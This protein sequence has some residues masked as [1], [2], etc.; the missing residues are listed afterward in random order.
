MMLGIL[1]L[2]LGR[3]G[4]AARVVSLI[5]SAIKAGVIMG[6]GLAAIVVVFDEG[7]RFSQYPFTISIAVGWPST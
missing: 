6:A 2:F 7:G 1:A 3:T 4:L 5:P